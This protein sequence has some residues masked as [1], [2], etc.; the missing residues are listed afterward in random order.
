ML[1]H[2]GAAH[3]YVFYPVAFLRLLGVVEEVKRA[4]QIAGDAA[5]AFEPDSGPG[6]DFA[7][8]DFGSC[9]AV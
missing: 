4:D 7:G 9:L 1:L 5:D 8:T 3:A 6:Q 2:M